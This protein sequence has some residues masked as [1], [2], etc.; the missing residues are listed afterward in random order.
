MTRPQ[1]VR[2][3]QRALSFECQR[4]AQL[5]AA[6]LISRVRLVALAEHEQNLP[7]IAAHQSRHSRQAASGQKQPSPGNHGRWLPIGSSRPGPII[8]L[9]H[10][11]P[12]G[13][14]PPLDEP[15]NDVESRRRSV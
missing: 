11:I 12:L 10:L 9:D 14:H 2:L 5:S 15:T 13:G 4:K 8:G 1:A 3:S 6:D 7:V